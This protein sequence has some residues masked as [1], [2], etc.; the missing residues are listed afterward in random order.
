MLR[1]LITLSVLILSRSVRFSDCGVW[2]VASVPNAHMKPSFLCRKNFP[3]EKLQL[4]SRDFFGFPESALDA[5]T[6][7]PA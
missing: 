7:A 4:I 2:C 5:Q 3:K 1:S 6:Y